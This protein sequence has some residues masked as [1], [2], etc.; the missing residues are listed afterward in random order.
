MRPILLFSFL[1]LLS[2]EMSKDIHITVCE[3]AYG[4]PKNLSSRK[5]QNTGLPTLAQF[6]RDS[7][8]ENH[9]VIRGKIV[10]S[11]SNKV[12]L[13]GW[14]P[15]SGG[16]Y[17]F[18]LSSRDLKIAHRQQLNSLSFLDLTPNTATPFE[19]SFCIKEQKPGRSKVR[20]FLRDYPDIYCDMFID[21]PKS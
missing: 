19:C 5:T 6:I 18:D 3:C 8:K 17:C 9:L 11:G 12:A 4:P 14:I 15:P 1:F 10:N 20:L 2:C 13:Y 7:E 21:K 16:N